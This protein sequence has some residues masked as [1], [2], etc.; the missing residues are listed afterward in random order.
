MRC[1]AETC[2]AQAGRRQQQ[3][4]RS[5][6]RAAPIPTVKLS[7]CSPSH[8]RQLGS[9]AAHSVPAQGAQTAALI[10][11]SWIETLGPD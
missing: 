4:A 1:G 11:P 3:L 9:S 6:R 8:P 7:C 2:A 10:F 5:R